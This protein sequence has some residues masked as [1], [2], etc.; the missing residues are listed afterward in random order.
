MDERK[1]ATNTKA[2]ELADILALRFECKN[3]K[4][5]LSVPLE[6]FSE[7]AQRYYSD[8]EKKVTPPPLKVCP[9]CGCEWGLVDNK[10]GSSSDYVTPLTKFLERI[11]ELIEQSQKPKGAPGFSLTLEIKDEEQTRD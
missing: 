4:S 7:S 6:R 11:K 3:C 8:R 2:I 9:V 1:K 10:A 5:V